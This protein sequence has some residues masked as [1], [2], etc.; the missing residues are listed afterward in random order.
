MSCRRRGRGDGDKWWSVSSQENSL[1]TVNMW[2]R[3]MSVARKEFIYPKSG[4]QET[5]H[6]LTCADSNTDTKTDRNRQKG[7]RRKT[8]NEF[9][10][11][12]HN[13][14][15]RCPVSRVGCHLSPVTSH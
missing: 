15:V 8:L 9:C 11:R 10:I 7:E 1:P 5:L 12:C 2:V 4:I 3:V 13:S 6:L 14:C